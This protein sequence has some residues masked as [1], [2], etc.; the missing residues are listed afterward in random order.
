MISFL[1]PVLIIIS[2]YMLLSCNPDFTVGS[3]KSKIREVII[4]LVLIC[5][6]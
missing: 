3:N 1:I 4:E 2:Y 5:W 6:P